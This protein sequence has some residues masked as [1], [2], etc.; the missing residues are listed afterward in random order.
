MTLRLCLWL[1]VAVFIG[2]VEWAVGVGNAFASLSKDLDPHTYLSTSSGRSLEDVAVLDA[3]PHCQN[4][5]TTLHSPSLL[6]SY[7]DHVGDG[8]SGAD[9][10]AFSRVLVHNCFVPV[11]V[12]ARQI[13]VFQFFFD[14]RSA[15]SSGAY[16][17]I[18][19]LN[20]DTV[21]VGRILVGWLQQNDAGPSDIGAELA[22]SHFSGDPGTFP[23]CRSGALGFGD[24]LPRSLSGTFTVSDGLA[25]VF[26][27]GSGVFE[28]AINQKHTEASHGYPGAS[29]PEHPL[30]PPSHILLGLK[31]AISLRAL[32]LCISY[33][34]RGL[35]RGGDA[36]DKVLDGGAL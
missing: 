12:I 7:G 11:G 10:G 22:L 6:A 26:S 23:G 18:G 32:P 5:I 33:V 8:L 25:G 16:T 4:Y 28:G 3:P 14:P 20:P 24:S 17:A 13:V 31:I 34:V 29:G 19:P 9:N 15:V 30:R 36:L 27:S 1:A 21:N 35:E 2:A